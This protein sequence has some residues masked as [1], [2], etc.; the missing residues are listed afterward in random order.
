MNLHSIA[1]ENPNKRD[2]GVAKKSSM[3]LE[4]VQLRKASPAYLNIENKTVELPE[5]AV[6]LLLEIINQ[7]A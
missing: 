6:K 5:P 4:T 3:M 2:I 7:I 1:I